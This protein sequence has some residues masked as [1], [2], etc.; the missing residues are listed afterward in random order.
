MTLRND[1][2][3]WGAVSRYFH[4]AAAALVLYLLI[5]GWWMTEF[6]PRASR[7]G[8]YEAHASVGY[9]LLAFMVLRM[10]WRWANTVPAQP[11]GTPAWERAA[12]HAGH[13]G[14]Y[15]LT[16]ASALSGWAL[17][18]TFR[19]PLAS[20]FGL[21]TIPPLVASSARALHDQLEAAHSWLSWALALVVILHVASALWHWLWKK[22]DV[23]QR[24]LH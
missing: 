11:A 8:H 12:V 13:W 5:H 10:L 3:R 7:F 19:R 1:A 21:F 6:A 18:G 22:D 2:A 24:M 23:M 17:A 14:L 16:L 20:F 4:W 15:L 9:G